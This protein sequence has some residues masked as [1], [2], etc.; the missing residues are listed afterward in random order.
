MFKHSIEK[1]R[2][3]VHFLKQSEQFLCNFL[4]IIMWWGWR[5]LIF[6]VGD[7]NKVEDKLYFVGNVSNFSLF[8]PSLKKF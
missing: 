3:C 8:L 6:E 2:K 5:F 4:K 7:A 1:S